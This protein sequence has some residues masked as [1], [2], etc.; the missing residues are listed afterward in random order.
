VYFPS[1][2][3]GGIGSRS[4]KERVLCI[5][6]GRFRLSGQRRWQVYGSYKQPSSFGFAI[7]ASG[8]TDTTGDIAW[9]QL[10]EI[11]AMTPKL[12]NV[13]VPYFLTTG[14][15]VQVTVQVD[16]T[17]SSPVTMPVVASIPDLYT[18]DES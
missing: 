1:P 5:R 7:D 17:V 10:G 2:G 4:G 12:I 14:H 6:S 18:M 13:L 8:A 15:T 3:S 11:V 16:A 9:G